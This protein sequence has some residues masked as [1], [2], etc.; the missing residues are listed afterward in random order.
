MLKNQLRW[1]C[2]CLLLGAA[3]G[4]FAETYEVG[5]IWSYK[6]RPQEKNS[7]LMVL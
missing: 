3:G 4:V 6:T 7:T 1:L 2:F 5:Q